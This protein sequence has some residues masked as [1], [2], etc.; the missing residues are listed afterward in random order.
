MAL[1]GESLAYETTKIFTFINMGCCSCQL[2][3]TL[4]TGVYL[5]ATRDYQ[6]TPFF[7][8]LQMF[9]MLAAFAIYT[10]CEA[11]GISQGTYTF[12][13]SETSV[14]GEEPP[15]DSLIVNLLYMLATVLYYLQHWLFSFE[16]YKVAVLFQSSFTLDD[17]REFEN[18][19]K[20]ARLCMY[21]MNIFVGL[22]L[23]VTILIPLVDADLIWLSNMYELLNIAI[24]IQMNYS[25]KKIRQFTGS[26]DQMSQDFL[27]SERL[28]K[29]HVF[30]FSISAL[31]GIIC[32][33]FELILASMTKV[34]SEG[35]GGIQ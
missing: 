5:C 19:V 18:K 28:M 2:L 25:L 34:E 27:K 33:T 8:I 4:C 10:T 23:V 31:L 11:R 14:R 32:F 35:G 30:T 12:L 20:S 17:S 6:S 13:V 9:L 24:V 15:P 22:F 7:I 26:L 16:Y 29:V 3:I 1:P 21:I